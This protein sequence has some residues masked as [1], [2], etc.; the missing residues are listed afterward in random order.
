MT[1]GRSHEEVYGVA[2]DLDDTLLF[3]VVAQGGAGCHT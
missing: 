1:G 3:E 2:A